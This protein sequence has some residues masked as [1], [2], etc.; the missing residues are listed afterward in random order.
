MAWLLGAVAVIALIALLLALAPS[1]FGGGTEQVTVP[2]LAGRTAAEAEAELAAAGLEVGPPV[3]RTDDAVPV[4]VVIETDP[5]SGDEVAPGSSVSLVLSSG[6]NATTVPTL[7]GLDLATAREA[8]ENAGLTLASPVEEVDSPEEEGRVLA[9]EPG[10]GSS[11]AP[12]TA[13]ALRVANGNNA[14]PSTVGQSESEARAALEQAGFEVDVDEREDEDED[15]G[16][17]IDQDPD[18]GSRR[19]GATVTI[20]VATGGD[21][22]SPDADRGG[23]NARAHGFAV[24]LGAGQPAGRDGRRCAA[25]GPA[26]RGPRR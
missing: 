14:I 22:P 25:A 4:D 18:E 24:A 13:V 1:L 11:V 19:L 5:P 3:R 2:D 23:N 15:E 17:V 16:T 7:L 26:D 20:V 9:A 6:P 10:D 21:D 8:L 12:G